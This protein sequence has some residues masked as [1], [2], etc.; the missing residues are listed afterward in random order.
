MVVTLSKQ[1]MWAVKVFIKDHTHDL[2]SQSK[3]KFIRSHRKVDYIHKDMFQTLH[4]AGIRPCKMFEILGEA[5][6]GI[7]NLPFTSKDVCNNISRLKH[8]LIDG[9]DAQATQI[10]FKN[11]RR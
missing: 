11:K 7:D 1:R 2:V 8:E 5:S 10:I 3:V 4:N 6:G 9:G